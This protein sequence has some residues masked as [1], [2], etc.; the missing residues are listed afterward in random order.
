MANNCIDIN[1][2]Q[3]RD[4]VE[5]SGLSEL[6]VE[7]YCY[8]YVNQYGRFPYLDEIPNSNSEPYLRKQLKI[9]K[10][11]FVKT[12][13][14]LEFTAS[15]KLED[16]IHYLNDLY[17]D[18]EIEF[19]QVTK[20]N[21]VLQ[22]KR[23][24]GMYSENFK[25]QQELANS[26]GTIIFDTFCDKLQELY[27]INVIPI[28][29]E[30]IPNIPELAGVQ[31]AP[32]AKAFIFNNTIYIN[33]DN[34]TI[35]SKIHELLHL[36]FSTMR[37]INPELYFNLISK[38][39]SFSNFEFIAKNYPNR[40]MGDLLEEVFVT[41]LAKHLAGLESSISNL[42]EAEYNEIYY[43]ITRML[44]TAFEGEISTKCIPQD[45]LYNFTF[46]KI[47]QLVNSPV[48]SYKFL[49]SLDETKIHRMLANTKSQLLKENRLEEICE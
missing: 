14:L 7:A 49:G 2:K 45:Q 46:G 21:I 35:D 4:L 34:A 25:Q 28:T 29:N 10:G 37:D 12:K 23:K 18:L 5:I 36:L 1:S 42:S 41:E 27:G 26:H 40:T 44:D 19:T 47:G 11:N 22:I 32:V 8:K 24:P 6:Y 3:F 9:T 43:Q 39:Q 31:D 15:T 13:K 20:E 33:T 48:T 16:A 17:R 30:E 38:A